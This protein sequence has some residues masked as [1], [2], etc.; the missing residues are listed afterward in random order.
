[1][2]RLSTL[3]WRDF[4]AWFGLWLILAEFGPWSEW[5]IGAIASFWVLIW[6]RGSLLTA[7]AFSGIR[8][9]K[10]FHF[11]PFLGHWL[12]D[13]LK[14]NIEVAKTVLSKDMRINPQFY[15]LESMVSSPIN[16]AI[17]ANAITLTPGTLTVDYDDE[18]IVVHGL[19]NHHIDDLKNAQ[20]LSHLQ[21]TEDAHE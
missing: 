17:L 5:V 21:A 19:R 7:A 4:I 20:F 15:T 10:F 13:L 3:H 11:V 9:Q 1:M 14:A 6:L 2:R 18:S 16:Q 12:W 8:K